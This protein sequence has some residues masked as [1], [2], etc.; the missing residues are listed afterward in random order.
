MYF[1]PSKNIK[2]Q[3][4]RLYLKESKRRGLD[5]GI[6]DKKTSIFSNQNKKN[7]IDI[8]TTTCALMPS[9]TSCRFLRKSGIEVS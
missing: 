5:C 1:F 8:T 6:E 7:N 3:G 4:G 2:T 9:I